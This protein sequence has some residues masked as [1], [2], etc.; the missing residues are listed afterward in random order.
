LVEI[1]ID[2]K[3]FDSIMMFFTKADEAKEDDNNEKEA[4]LEVTWY[5]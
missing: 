3:K 2:V 1:V 5:I 4:A